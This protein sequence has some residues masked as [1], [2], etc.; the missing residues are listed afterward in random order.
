MAANA[1]H[2]SAAFTHTPENE[3]QHQ[4]SRHIALNGPL[5]P[6]NDLALFLPMEPATRR[7]LPP[8]DPRGAEGTLFSSGFGGAAGAGSSSASRSTY[9]IGLIWPI[10]PTHGARHPELELGEPRAGAKFTCRSEMT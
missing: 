3:V 7:G 2:F 6:E 5:I 4:T 9:P 10:G 8:W 1:D